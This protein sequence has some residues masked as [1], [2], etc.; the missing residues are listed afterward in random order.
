MKRSRSQPRCHH[1]GQTVCVTLELDP[2][3]VQGG[4]SYV[5]WGVGD[6][7]THA[8]KVD[9]L[10][11]TCSVPE[12]VFINRDLLKLEVLP[13]PD[14][15]ELVFPWTQ[16]PVLREDLFEARMLHGEP[17]LVRMEHGQAATGRSLQA[18]AS[19][20]GRSRG[21]VSAGSL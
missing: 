4:S 11:A 18:S 20:T 2:S 3:E 12:R 5:V 16:I 19:G 1:D 17:V 10:S 6:V 7:A 8:A 14:P 9:G 15:E 21:A 13:A